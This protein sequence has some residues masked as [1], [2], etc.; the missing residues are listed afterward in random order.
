MSAYPTKITARLTELSP[1]SAK[2]SVGGGL[3]YAFGDIHGRYDLL[4]AL[5]SQ[6]AAD[7]A[8][9][10]GAR[11]PVLIFCGDY[12]DRG[13]ESAKV[14]EALLW[15]RRRTDIEVH[16]LKGNHEQA[17]LAFLDEPTE[18]EVW[19]RCGG[20]E[21]LRA[22]GVE[23][24][25]NA[26]PRDLIAARDALLERMPASHLWLLQ[27]LELIVL[28]GDYAFAHAGVRPGVR[29]AD[30]TEMDLL[31]IRDGFLETSANLE[32]VV[33]HGHTWVDEQPQMRAHRIGIDSGAYATGVLTALRLEDGA[34]AVLQAI[35]GAEP[36]QTWISGR[37][38]RADAG[39]EIAPT[40]HQ[41]AE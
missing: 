28:A 35:G 9:R 38:A 33:V 37:A 12:V 5:L 3:I 30:Q 15:L 16:A 18:G 1:V 8:A 13:A 4:K 27:N 40:H 29:L 34:L 6:V 41:A 31:W 19:L 11:R 23:V 26:S 2:T 32:K 20:E 22:Y 25:S 39:A 10:A 24:Q 17:L 36:D 21:T 7:W 14:I